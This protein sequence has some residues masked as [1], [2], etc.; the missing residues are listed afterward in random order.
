MTRKLALL[1]A[2]AALAV[3]LTATGGAQAHEPAD[4]ALAARFAHLSTHGNSN[5]SQ[6]FM[7]AIATMPAVARLQGSCCSPMDLPRYAEQVEGLKAYAQKPEIPPDPYDI[8]AAQAARL[9]ASYDLE[10][11]PDERA[12]YNYAMASSDEQGPCC[13]PCWRWETYGGL[14]KHL[15]RNRQFSGEQVAQLWDLSDGCGGSGHSHS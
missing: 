6:D 3:L 5:C 10:L 8:P 11:S 7:D 15:I 13:C 4:P 2:C 9:M 14:A 12:A 1:P